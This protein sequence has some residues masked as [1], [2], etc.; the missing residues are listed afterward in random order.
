MNMRVKGEREGFRRRE[1][2]VKENDRERG[3]TIERGV[4]I[5]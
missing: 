4:E 3:H 2:K 1:R 5:V